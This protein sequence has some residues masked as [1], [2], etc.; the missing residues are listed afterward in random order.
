[1]RRTLREW[2]VPGQRPGGGGGRALAGRRGGVVWS[3]GEGRTLA[4]GCVELV[5]PWHDVLHP[6]NVGTGSRATDDRW[7]WHPPHPHPAAVCKRAT[8]TA[9]GLTA[10]SAARA[11]RPPTAPALRTRPPRRPGRRSASPHW[12]R[13]RASAPAR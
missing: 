4:V 9:R 3:W 5:S 2:R 7:R 12:R 1:M 8:E 13:T 11:A 10:G 6:P